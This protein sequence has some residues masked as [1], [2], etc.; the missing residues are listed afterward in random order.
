MT[1]LQHRLTEEA[2]RRP[3]AGALVFK[4]RRL[5][6]ADLEQESSGLARRLKAAGVARGDRVCLLCPKSP[7]AIIAIL[8]VL[9]AD[10]IY[11]PLDPASPAPRLEKMIAACDDRWILAGGGV[12]STLD[13]LF[14]A[15]A[16]AATHAVGWLG[17][18]APPARVPPSFTWDDVARASSDLLSG[19]NRPGDAAHIL[20]T[21]GSTGTPKGV[22]ITHD[23]VR[24][25]IEWAVRYFGTAATDRI[26]GHPPLHF[27]LST[28][29]IFG[30]FTAG[31]EPH[32]L[33]AP[34]FVLAPQD[35]E[36]V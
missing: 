35:A 29:D 16:F 10:A 1:L 15:P 20:F 26:S 13:A 34:V 3:D 33:P 28:F 22:V 21:S 27:D 4:D 36:L 17:D 5:S 11:V 14:A 31:T 24:H 32:L 7:A 8:A 6:Y 19:T 25:F 18:G 2:G 30:T 12:A 9:K 23:N